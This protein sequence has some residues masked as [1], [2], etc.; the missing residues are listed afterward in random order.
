MTGRWIGCYEATEILN[1]SLLWMKWKG[2]LILFC[3]LCCRYV[4][5]KHFWGQN[6]FGELGQYHGCRCP[7]DLRRHV[8]SCH[9]IHVQCLQNYV[10]TLAFT[11]VSYLTHWGRDKMDAISQTT[12]SSAFLWMKMFEFRLKFHWSLFPRVQSTINQHWFR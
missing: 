10:S 5:N 12:F 2:W 4:G 11:D 9:G 7:G 6:I 3:R 1:N 8:I